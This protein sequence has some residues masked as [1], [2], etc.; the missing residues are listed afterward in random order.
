MKCALCGQ[1]LKNEMD[2]CGCGFQQ[3]PH[4]VTRLRATLRNRLTC[5]ERTV[6]QMQQEISSGLH[7]ADHAQVLETAIGEASA[8]IEAFN[9]A[10]FDINTE[11][12]EER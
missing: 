1:Y 12:G 9:L 6:Y 8:R 4:P 2:R 7:P 11:F 3:R 10:L 5:T